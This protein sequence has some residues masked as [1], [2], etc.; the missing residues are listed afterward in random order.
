MTPALLDVWQGLQVGFA[1]PASLVAA[2][3]KKKRVFATLQKEHCSR[4]TTETQLDLGNE[5]QE[6]ENAMGSQSD[7][8]AKRDVAVL[9]EHLLDRERQMATRE[10][11]MT[12]RLHELTELDRQLTERE[13][14][15]SDLE[16]RQSD[17]SSRELASWERRLL[18]RETEISE[19]AH[20]QEAEA[21]QAREKKKRKETPTPG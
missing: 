8:E 15:V 20:H 4:Q 16:V 18:N 9:E 3:S 17:K 10:R 7:D 1:S 14:M 11:E 5:S 12:L 21:E 13:K 19:R 2:V 6:E